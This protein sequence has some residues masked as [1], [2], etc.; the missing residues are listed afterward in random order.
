VTKSLPFIAGHRDAGATACPGDKLYRALGEI[1]S[2]TA[3]VVGAGKKATALTLVAPKSAPAGQTVTLSGRLS[4]EAGMGL[5]AHSVTIYRRPAGAR[6]ESATEVITTTDGNF[7]VD[8]VAE[9]TMKLIAVYQGDG[10]TWGS[11]SR[12]VKLAVGAASSP[13]PTSTDMAAVRAGGT[14]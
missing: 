13:T 11:L 1:R 7:S 3:A 12:I 14:A 6:W 5:I 9:S 4:D 2:E 8:V 10:A